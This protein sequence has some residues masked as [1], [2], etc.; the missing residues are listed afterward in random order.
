MS[1][2]LS[3]PLRPAALLA[4]RWDRTALFIGSGFSREEPSRI[5]T[6]EAFVRQLLEAARI[7]PEAVS[8]LPLADQAEIARR[9]LGNESYYWEWLK[10]F[11]ATG[12][13]I[14]EYHRRLARLPNPLIITTNYDTLIEEA[15]REAGVGLWVVDG[16][17]DYRPRHQGAQLVKIHGSIRNPQNMVVTRS[18]YDRRYGNLLYLELLRHL[19]NHYDL[20]FLGFSLSDPDL[21][22]VLGTSTAQIL[23]DDNRPSVPKRYLYAKAGNPLLA[24]YTDFRNLK[25]I[26]IEDYPVYHQVLD[27][28]H[29]RLGHHS[30]LFRYLSHKLHKRF[31][32]RDADSFSVDFHIDIDAVCCRDNIRQ[33]AHEYRHDVAHPEYRLNDFRGE[34]VRFESTADIAPEWRCQLREGGTEVDWRLDFTKPLNYGDR[35]AFGVH[36]HWEN[37]YPIWLEQMRASGIPDDE[38][39]TGPRDG[40][41]EGH[42]A[43][44][45]TNHLEFKVT[46]PTDYPLDPDTLQIGVSYAEMPKYEKFEPKAAIGRRLRDGELGA[47]IS[48]DSPVRWLNYSVCWTLPAKPPGFAPRAQRGAG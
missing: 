2:E 8:E 12:G 20:I 1:L 18:D 28:I 4:E 31:S 3:E 29:T 23:A 36:L 34:L 24:A 21:S 22:Q 7:A 47:V 32:W 16:Y 25:V 38:R 43:I 15:F 27:T 13:R 45:P 33:L 14:N 11:F 44:F 10:Q 30:P 48:V 9:T 40:N 17:V 35:F 39:A 5:E 37:E 6:W 42:Q 41:M 46:F 26:P 19:F